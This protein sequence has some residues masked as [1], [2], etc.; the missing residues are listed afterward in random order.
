[1]NAVHLI[2]VTRVKNVGGYLFFSLWIDPLFSASQKHVDAIF[3]L[4]WKLRDE[5]N[6]DG[7]GEYVRDG[8]TRG[9]GS[10]F[11]GVRCRFGGERNVLEF[12]STIPYPDGVPS[13]R[14][15]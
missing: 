15:V 14:F 8:I 6:G 13:P 7:G 12:S 5:T 9:L 1:M 10:T 4:C 2:F 11:V 3:Y